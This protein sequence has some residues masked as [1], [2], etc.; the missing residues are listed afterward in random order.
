MCDKGHVMCLLIL[1]GMLSNVTLQCVMYIWKVCILSQT[2]TFLFVHIPKGLLVPTLKIFYAQYAD[3]FNYMYMYIFDVILKYQKNIKFSGFWS[4][5]MYLISLYRAQSFFWCKHK[6][7]VFLNDVSFVQKANLLDS[8]S[9][10]LKF[11]RAKQSPPC[12][13]MTPP[14]VDMCRTD[15]K[16]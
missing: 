5:E 11:R 15:N 13:W 3:L 2:R 6:K 10:L 12:R 7:V 14:V 4:N 9:L 16:W 8:S 1:Q